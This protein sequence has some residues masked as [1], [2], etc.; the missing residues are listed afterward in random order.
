M[1]KLILIFLLALIPLCAKASG[2]IEVQTVIIP[3][4][5]AL[6]YTFKDD[7][8]VRYFLHVEGMSINVPKSSAEK[9][10]RKECKLELVK[11]YNRLTGKY[12]YTIREYK[13]NIDLNKITFENG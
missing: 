3:P 1:K 5:T 9:Y 12:K 10:L 2:W 4:T 6:N 7:G 8:S 13:G 11:W